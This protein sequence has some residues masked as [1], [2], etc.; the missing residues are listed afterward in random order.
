M[1]ANFYIGLPY[2]DKGRTIEEGFDCWGLVRLVYQQEFGIVL[3]S[4]TED[5]LSATE[6]KEIAQLINREK[7]AWSPVP[8]GEERFGDV[9][10][11][12]IIGYP[13]HVGVIWKP[14]FMLH[15]LEKINAVL[16]PYSSSLWR[17]RITGIIRHEGVAQ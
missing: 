6:A 13:T 11:L 12:R 2:H 3:P 17:R 14:G 10:I 1:D 15:T 9:V 8:L 4:Y 5:Y 7:G 16:E